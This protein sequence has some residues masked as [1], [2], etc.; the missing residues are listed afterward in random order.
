MSKYQRRW[1]EEELLDKL[2]ELAD[3]DDAPTEREVQET[4]DA[5]SPRTYARRFGAY[6]TA[7]KRAG[8]NAR[9]V[10]NYTDNMGNYVNRYTDQELIDWIQRLEKNGKPP[11]W[12]QV[13]EH[14]DAPDPET[15]RDRFGSWD[16]VLRAAGYESRVPAREDLIR[17]IDRYVAE[18]G[19]TPSL[20]NV[21]EWDRVTEHDFKTRFGTWRNA[22]H[23]AGYPA[24]SKGP[25]PVVG[26]DP[27]HPNGGREVDL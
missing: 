12:G 22:L 26:G 15:F 24:E 20:Y 1:G 17:L 5:P 18:H 16:D 13:K 6:S 8:L 7:C 21:E 19:E 27:I 14:D 10:E 11:E 3:G 4:P 23:A 25:A 2:R 9:D